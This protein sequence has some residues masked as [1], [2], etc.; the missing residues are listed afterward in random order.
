[1]H[2]GNDADNSN[3]D[4]VYDPTDASYNNFDLTPGSCLHQISHH[5]KNKNRRLNPYWILLDN[6]RT[7]HMFTNRALLENITE[8]GY[9]IDV[10]SSRGAPHCDTK[11]T[12]ENVG[13]VYLHKKWSGKYP[14]LCESSGQAPDHVQ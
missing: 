1:M 5:T 6:Q 10:S 4:K 11:G 2:F 14:V 13:D 9:L 12:L 3:E 8:T 7:L